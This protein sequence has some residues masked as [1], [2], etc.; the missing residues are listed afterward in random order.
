ML[1]TTD[2]HTPIARGAGASAETFNAP[3]EQLDAAI[4]T[5][6][7]NGSGT[8]TTINGPTGAPSGQKVIPVVSTTGF[9]IGDPIFLKNAAGLTESATVNSVSAGVSLTAV[10]NLTHTYVSGDP[11]S[12]SPVELVLARGGFGTLGDRLDYAYGAVASTQRVMRA[13]HVGASGDANIIGDLSVILLSDSTGVGGI[14]YTVSWAWKFINK[15][16]VRYPAW[17]FLYSIWDDATWNYLAPV[18]AQTGTGPN[19]LHFWNWSHGGVNSGW[20]L[21]DL[22]LMLAAKNPDLVFMAHGQNGLAH[23]GYFERMAA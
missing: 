4:G 6:V 7:T 15:L 8:S 13:L 23:P 21:Q 19:T 10:A 22:P 14:D 11:V 3:M 16:A 20:H 18:T 5:L 1:R 9:A 2:Y 17:T 12:K